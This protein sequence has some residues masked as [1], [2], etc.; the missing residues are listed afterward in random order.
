MN[1]EK[2]LKNKILILDG[3]IGTV[4]KNYELDS[5]DFGGALNCY[6][7]LNKTRPDIIQEIHEKYIL[8]GADIIETNS[9]NCNS[10]NFKKYG[11]EKDVY[12]L[13]KRSVEIAKEATKIS[14]RNIYIFGAVGP[15]DKSLSFLLKNKEKKDLNDYYKLKGVFKEQISGLIDGGVDGILIETVFDRL[16]AKAALV[17]SEELFKEKNKKLPIFISTSVDNDGNL[18]SGESIESSIKT[19]DR[20]YITGF[21][22]NCFSENKN[23]FSLLERMRKVSEKYIIAYPNAGFPNENKNYLEIIEKIHKNLDTIL[24][25]N[26][27]NIVGGC[28]GT[29]FEYIKNLKKIF[30][31]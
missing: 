18:V 16:N 29:D 24:E 30:E 7:V 28:C 17:A 9:F 3:A 6:E 5:K 25:K 11:L 31:K 12:E 2:E 22:I 13:A 23:L 20:N 14:K 27:L 21:G 1:L 26:L 15:T 10:L 19:L 8:A 4:L